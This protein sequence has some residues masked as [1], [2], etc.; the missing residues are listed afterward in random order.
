MIT[1]KSCPN[2]GGTNIAQYPNIGFAPH[3][4]YE[5]MPGVKVNAAIVNRYHVCQACNLIFQNPR[6]SDTELGQFYSSGTYRKTLNLTDEAKDSDE[7]HR[8]KLDSEIIKRHVESPNSHLDLGCSRGYLLDLVGARVKVGVEEDT[9]GVKVKGI[10]VYSKMSQIPNKKFDLV[11]AIHTLEHVSKPLDYL[12]NMMKF[13]NKEGYLIIEVPTWKSPGG[14]LRLA[15]LC[16]FEPD[17]LKLMCLK[18]GLKV[19]QVEFTPHLLLIC[20]VDNPA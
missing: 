5:I 2:C 14:P 19:E 11:T 20:K 17:V 7:M 16:H 12:R 8:A 6:L 18:V 9:K 1:L 15:H 3:V 10:D 13:V 4:I